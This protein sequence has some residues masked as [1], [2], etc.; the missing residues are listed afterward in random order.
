[1]NHKIKIFIPNR[2]T[3]D[4]HEKKMETKVYWIKL[5]MIVLSRVSFFDGKIKYLL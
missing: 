3:V 2:N 5:A 4:K 1:M